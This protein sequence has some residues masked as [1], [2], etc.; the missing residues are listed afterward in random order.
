LFVDDPNFPFPHRLRQRGLRPCIAIVVATL[1]TP[2]IVAFV[3]IVPIAI[4]IVVTWIPRPARITIVVGQHCAALNGNRNRRHPAEHRQQGNQN[5]QQ[6]THGTLVV[7]TEVDGPLST[8]KTFSFLGEAG[9]LTAPE[10]S[11]ESTMHR[12]RIGK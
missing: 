9:L 7:P 3:V 11:F 1:M 4:V 12:R 2:V 10:T 6:C 8:H 5:D